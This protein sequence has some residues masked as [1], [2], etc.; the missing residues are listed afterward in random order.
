MKKKNELAVFRFWFVFFLVAAIQCLCFLWL[1]VFFHR[2]FD[3]T[4]VHAVFSILFFFLK[5]SFQFAFFFFV[6]FLFCR[7]VFLLILL[8]SLSVCCLDLMLCDSD[9]N[10]S[11]TIL[12]KWCF[13]LLCL[14]CLRVVF[15]FLM[16]CFPCSLSSIS[17]LQRRAKPSV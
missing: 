13:P 17:S 2:S 16:L 11:K 14:L 6:F 5:F 12:E 7:P 8:C 1:R 15:S 10:D 9:V 4:T 3:S